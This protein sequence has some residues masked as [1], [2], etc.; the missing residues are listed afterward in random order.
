MGDEPSDWITDC[1]SLEQGGTLK[2]KK[3][4]NLE[5]SLVCGFIGLDRGELLDGKGSI[6]ETSADEVAGLELLEG[7][8]IELALKLLQDVR[9]LC[10]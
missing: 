7:L 8:L 10:N 5:R 4:T 6:D 3:A 2:P 1:T 9:K